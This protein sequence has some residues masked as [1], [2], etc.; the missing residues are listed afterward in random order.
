M[1]LGFHR[2]EQEHGVFVSED[3]QLFITIYV[4]NLLIFGADIPQLEKIQNHLSDCFKMTNLGNISHY[5]RIEVDVEVKKT[6][7]MTQVIYMKKVL[8]RFGMKDCQSTSILMDP[9]VALHFYPMTKKQ[10]MMLLF[11]TNFQLVS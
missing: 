6:I 11:N 3:K 5:L 2:L 7:K 8:K 9:G 10:V 4:D 1:K